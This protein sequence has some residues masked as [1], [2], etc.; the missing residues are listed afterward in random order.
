MAGQVKKK[1]GRPKNKRGR[2]KKNA[3]DGTS[4]GT[5][6]SKLARLND[7]C[8]KAA[9]AAAAAAAAFARPDF[10]RPATSIDRAI[11]TH[12]GAYPSARTPL[13]VPRCPYP[14]TPDIRTH[15]WGDL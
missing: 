11:P 7:T 8:V 4:D 14:S 9:A 1:M 13:P 3:S 15:A 2:P 6:T 10:G 12:R 5:S